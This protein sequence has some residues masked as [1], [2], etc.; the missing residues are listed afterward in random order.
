MS[1]DAAANSGALDAARLAWFRQDPEF[2]LPSE[3]AALEFIETMGLVL[4]FRSHSIQLP[5][6]ADACVGGFWEWG[7]D[8]TGLSAWEL[9]ETIPASGRA[10][11]ARLI[12][13]RGTFVR[14]SLVPSLLAAWHPARRARALDALA[15]LALDVVTLMGPISTRELRREVQ[16]MVPCEGREVRAALGDLQDR[17]LI[18]VAGGSVEGWSMHEWDLLERRV[19]DPAQEDVEQAEGRRDLVRAFITASLAAKPGAIGRLFGW[20][21]EETRT[22]VQELAREGSVVAD[23]RL[24]GLPGLFTVAPRL[25]AGDPSGAATRKPSKSRSRAPAK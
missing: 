13:G 19:P 23:V 9:K 16:G 8:P 12:G 17:L 6:L 3:A 25:L 5:N 2:A 21:A 7:L 15:R 20:S 1:A 18:T 24:E 22:A 10:F 14:W 4:L 11:Y